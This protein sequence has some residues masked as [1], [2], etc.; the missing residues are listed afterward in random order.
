MKAMVTSIGCVKAMKRV[1]GY[2]DALD[3]ARLTVHKGPTDG[4][5]TREFR[6]RILMAEHSPIRHVQY[7]IELEIPKW[8]STHFVRHKIGVEHYVSTSRPD[9][10]G[11]PRGESET[12][13]RHGM[14]INAQAIINIS[15]KRLCQNASKETRSAWEDV[16]NAL[17]GMDAI[18]ADKCRA[19]CVYRGFCPEIPCCGFCK[20]QEAAIQREAY[21]KGYEEYKIGSVRT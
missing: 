14:L 9:R 11:K 8:V 19:E 4:K 13:V 21:L 10:T 2:E 16:I 12:M 17:Y 6:T 1:S 15:R 18:L 3:A 5:P 7:W 20:T